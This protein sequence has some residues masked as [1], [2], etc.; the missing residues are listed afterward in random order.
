MIVILHKLFLL[1]CTISPKSRH[2]RAD[3][4]EEWPL[5][6][7]LI[8]F[9]PRLG[10]T[11]PEVRT[12]DMHA[13]GQFIAENRRARGLT[14]LQLAEALHVTDKAVSK[15]ERGLS[16]PDVTLLEPL[17]A[18]LG[19]TVAELMACRRQERAE[20]KGAEESMQNLL[21]IS[22]ASVRRERRRSWQRLGAVLVLLAVT[23][24]VAAWALMIE[25]KDY[26]YS[27]IVL[28]ETV[29]GVNY[30]YIDVPNTGHLLRLRCGEDIDFDAIQTE[31]EVGT[32]G[33]YPVGYHLEYRWNR[34][35]YQGTA[36]VCE[37]T[38][39]PYFTEMDIVGS[40]MGMDYN[41]ETLDT[42]FGYLDISYEY[43]D[44]YPDPTGNASL[45]TWNF[46]LGN[47]WDNWQEECLLTVKDSR[48][49]AN[50]DWDGDGQSELAVR[51]RW[52]E[53]PYAIY[54]L[55]SGPLSITYPDTVDEA[56]A[57]RLMTAKEMQDA[58]EWQL[59]WG[60]ESD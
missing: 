60:L 42:L 28:K 56:L 22:R 14:Q 21:T 46:W 38:G 45:Y 41:P 33:T 2:R 34:L 44:A 19:L 4:A 32:P 1:F 39:Y 49:F 27:S 47:G 23:A 29:D 51:T 43:V 48:G 13:F 37:N 50:V 15:W 31:Q 18:A 7:W 55:E 36:T 24:V 3:P 5:D 8:A 11:G 25:Y 35:T 26:W 52:E 53:K 59:F 40:S 17:A 20:Q 12:M 30:I 58:L 9:F 57:E 54:D 16:F 10:Y 6:C